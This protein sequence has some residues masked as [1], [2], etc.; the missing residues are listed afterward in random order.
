MT[1]KHAVLD[2]DRYFIIDAFSKSITYQNEEPLVLAH[3]E[4]N[5]ERFT[6]EMP[7]FIEGHDMSVCNKVEIHYINISTSNSYTRSS[8]IY[9]V[10]DLQ[11]SS[12]D[13]NTVLF[14]W[15]VSENATK[16]VGSLIFAVRLACIVNDR[17]DYS[18]RSAAFG[19][20]SV[21]ESVDNADE[22][23]A[24]YSD[25]LQKWYNE[26]LLTG[27]MGVNMVAD[28]RDAAIKDIMAIDMVVE[29]EKATL[30]K[31]TAKGD[32]VVN[33]IAESI[34]TAEAAK[35]QII[36]DVIDRIPVY[37]GDTVDIS[38]YV[39]VYSGETEEII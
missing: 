13:E 15:L 14:S 3:H 11:V 22:I 36:V 38:N 28:A 21:V 20:I 33:S 9:P 29:I 34:T 32:E 8:D 26:L 19:G 23:V 2:D 17:V 10:T 16:Y 25:I 37:D 18:W 39:S 27:T 6:F 35:E 7:R 30:N 5:S 1:H 31:I 24:Q 12:D 4:H